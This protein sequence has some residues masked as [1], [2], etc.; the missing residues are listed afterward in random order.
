MKVKT[1]VKAGGLSRNH[2]ETIAK[3]KGL[4][5]KTSV[6]AGGLHIQHNETIVRA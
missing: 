2:N 6:K 5:V 1:S 3:A 4:R